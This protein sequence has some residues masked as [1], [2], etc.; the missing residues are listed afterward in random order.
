MANT[1]NST[2]YSASWSGNTMDAIH[3]S[4]RVLPN[5][6]VQAAFQEGNSWTHFS[7]ATA[8]TQVKT[9]VGTIVAVFIGT[10]ATGSIALYDN[11]SAATPI[12]VVTTSSSNTVPSF[13]PFGTALATG[14][15]VV[16]VGT[17]P[18]ITITYL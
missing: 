8:G 13:L 1:G 9:G 11:T 6:V 3:K 4:Y 12:A 17:S 16:I 14:L 18:D 10:Q 15:Y 5:G 7:G 2:I